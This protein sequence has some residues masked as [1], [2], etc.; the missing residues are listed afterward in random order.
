MASELLA[1]G[2]RAIK[3]EHDSKLHLVGAATSKGIKDLPDKCCSKE[4]PMCECGTCVERKPFVRGCLDPDWDGD[5]CPDIEDDCCPKGQ[6]CCGDR[7]I[8]DLQLPACPIDS[9]CCDLPPPPPD[10]CCTPDKPVCV[11]GGCITQEEFDAFPGPVLCSPGPGTLSA[12][13]LLLS[14][15]VELGACK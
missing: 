5:C 7:C 13:D 9:N 2:P 3:F 11:C 12:L 8:N 10:E 14:Y 4:F 15:L 1:L 6:Y